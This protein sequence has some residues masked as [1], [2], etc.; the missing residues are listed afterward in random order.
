MIFEKNAFFNILYLLDFLV[1]RTF[2][3]GGKID[4]LVVK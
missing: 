3:I 4:L 1:L 2:K